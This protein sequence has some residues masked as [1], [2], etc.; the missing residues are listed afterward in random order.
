[1]T[2]TEPAPAV[3]PAYSPV[4]AIFPQAAEPA[5]AV[6]SRATVLGWG[7]LALGTIITL[8]LIYVAVT[9]P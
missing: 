6:W 7:G 8:V 3:D 9:L 2:A 1:V 5:P 4:S